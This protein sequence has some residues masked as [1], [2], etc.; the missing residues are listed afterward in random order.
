MTTDVLGELDTVHKDGH[1]FKPMRNAQ[2]V[3]RTGKVFLRPG[4][5]PG[6]VAH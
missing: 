2:A 4:L 6:F 3:Q 5:L 1:L